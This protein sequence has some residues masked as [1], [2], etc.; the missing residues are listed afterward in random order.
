MTH[1]GT[2]KTYWAISKIESHTLIEAD[3]LI[4]TVLKRLTIRV[5]SPL[6]L[7]SIIQIKS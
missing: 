6:S 4:L 5:T 7:T 3:L 2:L 1:S